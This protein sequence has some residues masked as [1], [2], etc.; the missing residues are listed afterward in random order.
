MDSPQ[1]LKIILTVSSKVGL[2]KITMVLESGINTANVPAYDDAKIRVNLIAVDWSKLARGP[3]HRYFSAS[4][5]V[6]EVGEIV[7]TELG[8]AFM[9]GGVKGEDIHLIG[10]S[11]GAHVS[12]NIGRAL[13]EIL[14]QKV[15]RITGAVRLTLQG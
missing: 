13:F 15:A 8:S 11:L 9:E 1:I 10:H 12:G 6:D 3:L 14:G 7:A 2:F 4:S 5:Y